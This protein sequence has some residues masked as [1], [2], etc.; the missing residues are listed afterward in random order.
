MVFS[1]RAVSKRITGAPQLHII[2]I[3][4]QYTMA[5]SAL[6][7]GTIAMSNAY[8]RAYQ[9]SILA[10]CLCIVPFELYRHRTKERLVRYIIFNASDTFISNRT[11]VTIFYRINIVM[12]ST[13]YF[14]KKPAQ[15]TCIFVTIK[16]LNTNLSFV[17]TYFP[18]RNFA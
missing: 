15:L 2:Y 10:T 5:N 4:P 11:T 13:K 6:Y 3:Q 18:C 7:K 14:E 1:S 12:I 9:L 8:Q 16:R 17:V